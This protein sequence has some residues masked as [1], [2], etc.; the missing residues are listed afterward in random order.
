MHETIAGPANVSIASRAARRI[1]QTLV[2]RH[3]CRISAFQLGHSPLRAVPSYYSLKRIAYFP[4]LGLAFSRVRKNANTFVMKTLA[5]LEL[6]QDLDEL[7]VDAI[8]S[9]FTV[10]LGDFESLRA[11][12]DAQLLTVARNPFSRTL[13]AFLN[14]F[15]ADSDAFR[16]RYGAFSPDPE[17]FATFLR[18]L[19]QGN[20]YADLHWAPQLHSMLPRHYYTSILRQESL[21]TDLRHVLMERGIE[22]ESVHLAREAPEVQPRNHFADQRLQEYYRQEGLEIVAR[23]FAQDFIA[24]GYSVDPLDARRSPS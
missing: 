9:R 2:R 10:R 15:R 19:D 20:L 16:Q 1:E 13:S 6:G 24:L 4:E 12:R 21:D 22:L 8:K 23:L 5:T 3:V 14:K 18:F 7:D 17:G 11:I